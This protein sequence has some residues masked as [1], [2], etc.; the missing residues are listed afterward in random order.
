MEETIE[1]FLKELKEIYKDEK[2]LDS[3]E[4]PSVFSFARRKFYSLLFPEERE[5]F[6]KIPD[7][8][9]FKIV[10]R[11][12]K[13]LFNGFLKDEGKRGIWV[14]AWV[15]ASLKAR[16]SLPPGVLI[17]FITTACAE[18]RVAGI[19]TEVQRKLD[20]PTELIR[21]KICTPSGKIIQERKKDL[22]L[23]EKAILAYEEKDLGQLKSLIEE[24]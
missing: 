10:E 14:L 3:N 15:V 17:D 18:L 1:I 2:E 23:L 12:H 13:A 4:N 7:K 5:E 24:R 22:S 9:F 11:A 19:L 6:K 8:Y 20:L 16:E 21:A